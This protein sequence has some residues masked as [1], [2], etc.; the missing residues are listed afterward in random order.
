MNSS[1]LHILLGVLA[2]SI[3]GM[4]VAMIFL[5]ANYRRLRVFRRYQ[6]AHPTL[7][8]ELDKG[9]KGHLLARMQDRNNRFDD[10][11]TIA[12]YS[13]QD[14]MS[15]F[16]L[17][18]AVY[19]CAFG[20]AAYFLDTSSS[21]L[22]LVPLLLLAVLVA[23]PLARITITRVVSGA[24]IRAREDVVRS[25][26]SLLIFLRLYVGA[27]QSA[28][29]A[30]SDILTQFAPVMSPMGVADVTTWVSESTSS[31]TNI[32]KSLEAFG[33]THGISKVIQV[34]TYIRN[35][36]EGGVPLTEVLDIFIQDLYTVQ[37][38]SNIQIIQKRANSAII[39]FFPGL[40]ALV[41]V[42]LTALIAQ[43]GGLGTFGKLFGGF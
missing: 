6:A 42:F 29:Q 40:F 31:D 17:F 16:M 21:S 30:V 7:L 4:V 34:G 8:G 20:V 28:S 18:W 1:T 2:A 27:G 37:Q 22:S 32:G 11:C 35:A 14:V 9:L 41:A 36:I 23:F 3:I 12:G 19:I 15:R 26:P 39:A 33:T 10:E 25:L 38:Q 43:T 5:V 24:A 13:D